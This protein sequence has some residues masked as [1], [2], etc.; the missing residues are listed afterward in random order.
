MKQS[1]SKIKLE[2]SPNSFEDIAPCCSNSTYITAKI[3]T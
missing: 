2:K 1:I 3:V